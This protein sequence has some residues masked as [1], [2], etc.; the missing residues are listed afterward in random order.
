MNRFLFLI[1]Y[2]G[3]GKT[4]AGRLVAARLGCP[5][6]DAD[7]KLE[8]DSGRPIREI[9][10]TEGEPKFRDLESAVLAEV[11]AGPE[12]LVST[13]G[14]VV[15]REANRELMA[16]HGYL[17]W[18]SA[19]ADTL[20]FVMVDQHTQQNPQRGAGEHRGGDHQAFMRRIELQLFG[21]GDTQRPEQHPDH[22]ADVEIQ[23]GCEQCR[24]VARLEKTLMHR[25]SLSR[26]FGPGE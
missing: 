5:F 15:L 23:E 20:W 2:R 17:V 25:C 8:R 13:G 26:R 21:D 4:T 7:E 14:G 16:R 11:C 3:S 24:Q 6:I 19:D 18:L 1:G 10:A 12:C 9:F 22:E